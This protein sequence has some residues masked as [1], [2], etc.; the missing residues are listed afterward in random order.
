ME[1]IRT[2]YLI[3]TQN[4]RRKITILQDVFPTIFAYLYEDKKILQS[5]L[6]TKTLGDEANFVSVENGIISGGINSGESLYESMNTV[7]IKN[8]ITKQQH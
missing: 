4:C 1:V 5:K 7:N 3:A 6:K 8:W 2:S